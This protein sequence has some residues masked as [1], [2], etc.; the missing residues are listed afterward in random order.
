MLVATA[1]VSCSTGADGSDETREELGTEY[2]THIG[3]SECGTP[4]LEQECLAELEQNLV[5]ASHEGCEGELDAYLRCAANDAI[6]CI[7]LDTSPPMTYPTLASSTCV[8]RLVEFHECVTWVAPLCGIGMGSDPSGAA[9]CSVSCPDFS[10]ACSG[11]SANG[12]VSCVCDEGPNQGQ[13]FE[14]TDCGRDLTYKTGHTC[15]YEPIDDDGE[16]DGY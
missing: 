9:L 15:G 11:P 12:A 14:A 8:E 3:E 5:D 2:C 1:G 7:T 6:E 13:T 10:S 16:S 4:E